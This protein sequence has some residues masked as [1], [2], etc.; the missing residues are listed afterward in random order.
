MMKMALGENP[1]RC[2][3]DKNNYSRMST[4]AKLRE[5]LD[6]PLESLGRQS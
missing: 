1:K 3:K 6:P 4:A 5:A 2:Y